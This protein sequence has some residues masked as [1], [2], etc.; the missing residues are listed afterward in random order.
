M[1][2][3][4][5]VVDVQNE[6][7]PSGQRPVPNHPSALAAIR[8]HVERARSQRLP[9]AWVRHYNRPYESKA[10]VPGSWGAELS[11]GLAPQ[12]GFGPERL[13]EKDV[14][15][16]FTTTDLE[17]WLRGLDVKSVLIIGFYAH[18]CVSTTVREALVRGF[19]VHIDPE[20]TGARDLEGPVLGRQSADEVLR[21]AL[22]H[23]QNMGAVITSS[24]QA[25]ASV[26]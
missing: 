15:G 5:I 25:P 24:R 23:L 19:D 8:A 17:S 12:A 6:F 21:S 18:M 10:F 11:P 2:D 1:S 16:A 4:L 9:I 26:A 22:L 20:A 7:S 14:F 13:F 3:A